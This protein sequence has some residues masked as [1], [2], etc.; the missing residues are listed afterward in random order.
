MWSDIQW[1]TKEKVKQAMLT[2]ENTSHYIRTIPKEQLNLAKPNLNRTQDAIFTNVKHAFVSSIQSLESLEKIIH[3][4]NP[5]TT[6]KR[7][8]AMVKQ[9]GK[10]IE[11]CNKFKK[12]EIELILKDGTIKI[13]NA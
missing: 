1:I 3:I 10:Y 7:G 13:S 8:F 2:L 11:S 5:D 9:N 6:L 12:G 4:L